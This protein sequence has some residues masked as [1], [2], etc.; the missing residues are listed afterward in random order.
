MIG[1]GSEQ[2]ERKGV[3]RRDHFASTGWGKGEVS[4]KLSEARQF[5]VQGSGDFP[6]GPVAKT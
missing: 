3:K 1:M 4:R 2:V 6:G 5:S